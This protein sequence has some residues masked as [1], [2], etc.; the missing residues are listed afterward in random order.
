MPFTPPLPTTIRGDISYELISLAEEVWIDS[1]KLSS[2]YSPQLLEGIRELLRKVNSY[3]SNRLESEGTH[4]VDIER[5][6]RKDFDIDE[7]KRNLQQLSLS[8]IQTQKR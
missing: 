3:Y 8:Y 1:A 7:K 6:M 5:A 2:I 4:P